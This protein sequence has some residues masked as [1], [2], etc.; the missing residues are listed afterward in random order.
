MSGGNNTLAGARTQ[1]VLMTI[2]HTD[3]KRG[4]VQPALSRAEERDRRLTEVFDAAI[5]EKPERVG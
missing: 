2:L 4:I 1:Q 3:R 5:T